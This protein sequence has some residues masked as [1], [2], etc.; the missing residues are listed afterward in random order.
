MEKS[1]ITYIK[2][3]APD[4]SIFETLVYDDD[5]MRYISGQALSEKQARNKFD[6]ILGINGQEENLGYFKV[7]DANGDFLGDCKLERHKQD[8]SKLEIGY[9]LKKNYWGQ[10]YGIQLCTAM[11]TLANDFY[12][13]HD[14]IGIIDPD[15]IASKRLLEK[16]EFESFFIGME[17]ELPT[18]KLILKRSIL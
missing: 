13:N 9:I 4:F 14:I 10:G 6:S 15:N 5:I 3:T 18:E 17:D 7:Y 1:K 12:P 8:S 16:F 11:L 2:Y